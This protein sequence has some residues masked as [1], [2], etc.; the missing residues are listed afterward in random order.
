MGQAAVPA[1]VKQELLSPPG[2][3]VLAKA[4]YFLLCKHR[5]TALEEHSSF[6]SIAPD[7]MPVKAITRLYMSPLSRKNR[8]LSL[9]S[10]TAEPPTMLQIPELERGSSAPAR[11]EQTS[12]IEPFNQMTPRVRPQSPRVAR[13]RPMSIPVTSQQS[14][15]PFVAP[16]SAPVSAINFGYQ[17]MDVDEP[18][19]GS[20][21]SR[22][23][24]RN[25]PRTPPRTGHSRSAQPMSAPSHRTSFMPPVAPPPE[26]AASAP[27]PMT[28]PRVLSHVEHAR[29]QVAAR[30]QASA[31]RW[32]TATAARGYEDD[33]EVFGRD[34]KRSRQSSYVTSEGHAGLGLD[35]ALTSDLDSRAERIVTR[36]AGQKD[37]KSKSEFVLPIGLRAYADA[38][39][40]APTMD[41]V[42]SPP[43]LSTAKSSILQSPPLGEVKG[44]FSNLFHWKAHAYALPSAAPPSAAR[45][46]VARLLA[47]FGAEVLPAAEGDDANTTSSALQ[48]SVPDTYDPRTGA[49]LNKAVRFRAEIMGP[50][51]RGAVCTVA[52]VHEKGAE[53]TLRALFQRVRDEWRLSPGAQTPQTPMGEFGKFEFI[54]REDL[55]ELEA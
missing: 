42:S 46:E 3:G 31:A 22:R 18:P 25:D 53:R 20:R 39:T 36:S 1:A 11:V 35:Q 32:A 50:Q 51:R 14:T 16:S 13:M 27:A 29:A 12:P 37:R 47:W 48:C 10:S 7:A 19:A 41:S 44:W 49:L 30:S 40:I 23:Q 17:P 43:P 8:P 28:A 26:Y 55:V 9:D 24:S 52:L 38:R 4:F 45:D 54:T 34:N 15:V 6:M 21:A 33:E 5:E 2:E